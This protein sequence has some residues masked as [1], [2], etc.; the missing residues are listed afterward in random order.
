[1]RE[2]IAAARRLPDQVAAEPV[3]IDGQQ[4]QVAAP[5]EVPPRGLGQL[6]LGRHVD[7][8][9]GQIDGR[10]VVSALGDGGAPFGGVD[11]LVGDVGHSDGAPRDRG[12]RKPS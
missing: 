7:V 3:E 12:V 9:V 4:Q 5:G 8:A 1:M 6:R 2:Q 10:A 11:D